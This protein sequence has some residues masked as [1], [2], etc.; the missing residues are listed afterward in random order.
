MLDLVSSDLNSEIKMP[1]GKLENYKPNNI[2]LTSPYILLFLIFLIFSRRERP[3]YRTSQNEAPFDLM[4]MLKSAMSHP[5]LELVL[6]SVVPYLS[7]DE[8]SPI[9]TIAGVLQLI[10]TTKK[11][12]NNSYRIPGVYRA[13]G[14]S[15]SEKHMEIVKVLKN[16]ANSDD[17]NILEAI[18]SAFIALNKIQ[19]AFSSQSQINNNSKVSDDLLKIIE[20]VDKLKAT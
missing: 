17:R 2:S 5:E 18:E 7:E 3:G 6:S 10:N 14:T 4:H 1:K 20:S 13:V 8:Q 12:K 11:I 9:H 19:R 16:Y 15:N